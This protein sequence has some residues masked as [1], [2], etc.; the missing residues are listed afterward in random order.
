MKA[1]FITKRVLSAMLCAVML[2]SCWVFTAPSASAA[3]TQGTYYVRVKIHVDNKDDDNR[4]SAQYTL[5]YTKPDNS[6]LIRNKI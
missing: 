2:F 1:K 5:T 3:G 6:Q 4:D